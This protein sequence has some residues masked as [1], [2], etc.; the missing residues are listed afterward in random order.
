[1]II[2]RIVC[3]AL[4]ACVLCAC[5]APPD[6]RRTNFEIKGK[7]GIAKYDPKTGKLTKLDFDQDKNGK[8]ESVGY[9]DG[10]RIVRFEIDRDED[11]KVDRWEEYDEKNKVVRIA[12]SSRD[13]EVQDTF[14]YPD[15]KGFLAKVETDADR[16]GIIE[17]R[18]FFVPRPGKPEERVLSYVEFGLDANG[19]PSLRLHYGPDG[20]L[21]RT[22]RLR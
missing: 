18:E 11:G 15:E 6:P 1:M 5:S 7:E 20:Q 3:A 8:M 19:H 4:S 13:D 9:F 22:E 17:K 2:L 12:T 10:T 16:N 14:A 21:Q